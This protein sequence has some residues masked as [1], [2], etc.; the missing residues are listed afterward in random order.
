[1]QPAGCD[2][3]SHSKPRGITELNFE[4]FSEAEANHVANDGECLSSNPQ[5]PESGVRS[6]DHTLSQKIQS[7]SLVPFETILGRI[8][9]RTTI[10]AAEY[11]FIHRKSSRLPRR[12]A[13]W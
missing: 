5:N 8:S 4:N 11:L 3:A 2:E 7:S 13:N 10:A 9:L 6:R 12:S 1:M